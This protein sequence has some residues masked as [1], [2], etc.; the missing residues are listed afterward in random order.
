[1]GGK[2]RV[3]G[4]NSISQTTPFPPAPVAQLLRNLSHSVPKR[5]LTCL[6]FGERSPT[7]VVGDNRGAVT[8]Y[9]V[10]DPVTITHEGP[11]QQTGRLKQVSVI[12]IIFLVMSL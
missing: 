3:Q 10:L 8:V 5:S 7:I 9:R 6:Q 4:R 11:V 2:Q 1:V 12:C